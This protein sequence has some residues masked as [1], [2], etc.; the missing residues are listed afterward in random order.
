MLRDERGPAPSAVAWASLAAL[1]VGYL[2]L[3]GSLAGLLGALVYATVVVCAYLVYPTA[4]MFTIGIVGVLS[5]VRL[6]RQRHGLV[7]YALAP[8]R[9]PLELLSAVAF[10]ALVL[11][12]PGSTVLPVIT[13]PRR[14][15]VSQTA[16]AA[17]FA[18]VRRR[19]ARG[20]VAV[21]RP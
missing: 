19:A 5:L 11:V 17:S 16:H 9:E 15:S 14:E 1:G 20:T 4:L 21:S 6:A 2:P 18:T 3:W 7:R 13:A 12:P 10:V 8:T